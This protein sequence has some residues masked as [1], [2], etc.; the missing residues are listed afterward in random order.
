MTKRE[1]ILQRCV[2]GGLRM[3]DQRRIIAAVLDEAR[4]H[5]D[6]EALHARAADRD[7]AISLATVYRTMRLFEEAGI[8]A[9]LDF[10]DGRARYEDAERSHHDHLIDLTTGDVVEFVS[11][12]I[13]TLQRQI[14]ERLGYRIVAHRLELYAVPLD[15]SAPDAPAKI[16]G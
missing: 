8:V 10:R 1:T 3:T 4:D 13:E 5:P 15:A 7:P 16:T 2:K 11:A 9:K 6:V 14:A 12:E